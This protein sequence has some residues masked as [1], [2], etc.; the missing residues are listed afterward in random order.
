MKP[1]WSWWNNLFDVLLKRKT[2]FKVKTVLLYRV[3]R[4]GIILG[5]Q[6]NMEHC[7]LIKVHNYY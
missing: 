7:I 4:V 5:Y 6:T 1:T 3:K 2:L